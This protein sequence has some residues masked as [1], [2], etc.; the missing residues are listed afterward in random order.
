MKMPLE[1]H[2]FW[3]DMYYTYNMRGNVPTTSCVKKGTQRY[4]YF[5][6]VQRR[7]QTLDM[8]L[9]STQAGLDTELQNLQS[10]LGATFGFAKMCLTVLGLK[11][12]LNHQSYL[13]IV[14]VEDNLFRLCIRY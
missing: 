4:Q 5:V 13:S 2:W 12:L 3:L 7:P 14:L 6:Q 11:N 8:G 9:Y 1:F 10:G